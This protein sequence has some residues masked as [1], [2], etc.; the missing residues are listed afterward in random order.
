M[1]GRM[2]SLAQEEEAVGVVHAQDGV[3][4][5]DVREVLIAG[6]G[7]EIG[8][9]ELDVLLSLHAA[10]R[11]TVHGRD[12]EGNDEQR[13]RRTLTNLTWCPCRLRGC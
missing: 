10:V 3:L 11:R 8:R 1:Y 7:P 13:P 9:A 12:G 5:R 4:R 2:A 6:E